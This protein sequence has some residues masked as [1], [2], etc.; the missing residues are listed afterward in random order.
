M[1]AY[2]SQGR[3]PRSRL[4][5]MRVKMWHVF[6]FLLSLPLRH[7]LSVS[8]SSMRDTNSEDSDEDDN[9]V[10]SFLRSMVRSIQQGGR[11]TA[12]RSR[13]PSRGPSRT[14]PTV[15]LLCETASVAAAAALPKPDRISSLLWRS[16]KGRKRKPLNKAGCL[17]RLLSS[18]CLW[19]LAWPQLL[20]R[21]GAGCKGFA[22][23]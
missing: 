4:S 13:C 10:R 19:H 15:T 3:L 12:P 6:N 7:G 14:N 2:N 21:G 18:R 16:T 9:T 1:F 5:R 11:D 20:A 17:V 22:S 23:H 8:P